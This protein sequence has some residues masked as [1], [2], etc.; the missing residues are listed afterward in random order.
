L[1]TFLE[2][3]LTEDQ[4]EGMVEWLKW[5]VEPL[6]KVKEYIE[7]TSTKRAAWIC[8]NA[9]LSVSAILTQHPRLFDTPGMV[10]IL[11]YLNFIWVYMYQLPIILFT[12]LLLI[13][14]D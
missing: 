12:F 7:K 1:S 13:Y 3:T 8:G 11:S 2:S 10:S 4:Y 14:L 9:N 5:H 6:W